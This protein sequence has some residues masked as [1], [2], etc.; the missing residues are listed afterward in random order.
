[1]V[2]PFSR[3]KSME[4]M[5][6]SPWV[7][8]WFARKVPDCLRR[9][10]TRVVLPWSTCAIIAMLRMCCIF[11]SIKPVSLPFNGKKIKKRFSEIKGNQVRG[12]TGGLCR[13]S[14]KGNRFYDIAGWYYKCF[15]TAMKNDAQEVGD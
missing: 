3:S 5:R 8:A 14:S 4:S 12:K 9:Q 6:R 7:S 13:N 2:M 11:I 15:K 1:M 10:S